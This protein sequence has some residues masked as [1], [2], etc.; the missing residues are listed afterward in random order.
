MISF[1]RS[2]V[3]TSRPHRTFF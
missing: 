1:W 2:W 3:Q